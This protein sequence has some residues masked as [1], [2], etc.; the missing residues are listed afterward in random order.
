MSKKGSEDL[1]WYPYARYGSADPLQV[2]KAKKEF[3]HLNDGRKIIDGVSSWWVNNHGH[4]EPSIIKAVTKLIAELDHVIFSGFTHQPALDLAEILVEHVPGKPSKIFYS[5]N[6]S[7]AVEVALKMAIQYWSNKGQPKKKILVFSGSY[8]GDTFGAM[9]VSERGSF[10]KPF[11]DLLFEPIQNDP[12]YKGKEQDSLKQL[13]DLLKKHQDIAAF[14]YEPLVLGTAGMRMYSASAIEP[15]LKL[16]RS[17]SVLLIAD[18]VMTGFGRTGKLFASDHIKTKPDLVCLSKGITGGV[19]PLGVTTVNSEVYSAFQD[20]DPSRTFYHGHSY[21]GNPIAISAAVASTKLFFKTDKVFSDIKRIEA[22]HKTFARNLIRSHSDKLTEVR[23]TGTIIALELKTSD[24]GYHF[25]RRDEL[26]QH[27]ISK[28]ILLRP[29][30]NII[31]VLPP[32]CTSDSSLKK[33]YNAIDSYLC[34]YNP[35]E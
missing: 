9:S 33:I 27:F 28:G 31:Y 3:L 2:V 1:I 24:Q 32:Y 30:G 5:D 22:S 8:H 35:N 11:K 7:T 10:T 4:A 26:Y 25:K 12:P 18:E 13:E 14:I 21:T 23:H 17:N 20:P 6:G 19:L 15:I 34:N 29:L 16:L